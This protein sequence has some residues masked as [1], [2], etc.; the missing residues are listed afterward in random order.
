MGSKNVW[1][2]RIIAVSTLAI[3]VLVGVSQ[4]ISLAG[5]A[6]PDEHLF[7]RAPAAG[8]A[9]L[10]VRFEIPGAAA[11]DIN[12]TYTLDFG[13]GTST[14]LS[15]SDM[16]HR[17]A[18]VGE[19]RSYN[20]KLTIRK[21]EIGEHGY[22]TSYDED[23][24]AACVAATNPTFPV[25]TVYWCNLGDSTIRM[26]SSTGRTMGESTV[27]ADYPDVNNPQGVYISEATN[28]DYLAGTWVTWTNGGDN[29]IRAMEI[30]AARGT[31]YTLADA[32]T[33][34]VNDARGVQ[35]VDDRLFWPNY[36]DHT[37]RRMPL[38][39]EGPQES[40][41]II[42]APDVGWP[43]ALQVVE[44]LGPG[45]FIYW[46][47]D[48]PMIRRCYIDGQTQFPVT[49]SV[50]I[51]DYEHGANGPIGLRVNGPYVYWTSAGDSTI[52]RCRVDEGTVFPAT[53]E[54]VVST[55]MDTPLGPIVAPG[56]I[57]TSDG[58]AWANLFGNTVWDCTRPCA[59]PV[60][61]ADYASLGVY[62]PACMRYTA[63]DPNNP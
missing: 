61:A 15:R 53:S 17:Y 29:T 22:Q 27:I 4:H 31:S 58:I 26:C 50:V 43:I 1:W 8:V 34:K 32:G 47:N 11:G 45:R 30:G 25:A 6:N 49:E 38:S 3:A 24:W 46:V 44:A 14:V 63:W 21:T 54:A 10:W 33:S 36:G 23:E 5:G 19:D 42:G 37:I 52:R 13:D 18:Y 28:G 20:V 35:I 16:M 57:V 7:T 40:T 48:N 51:C 9:L 56:L 41:T 59:T 60:K 12:T 55:N 39:A 2:P 62:G